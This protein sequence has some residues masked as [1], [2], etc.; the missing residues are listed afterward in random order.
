MIENINSQ[1]VFTLVCK[2]DLEMSAITLKQLTNFLITG[3]QLIVVD[4]GSLNLNDIH[5]LR[6][7]I[8]E[9]KF[10]LKEE[11]EDLIFNLIG[12]RKNILKYR[13][14]FVLAFKLIDIPLIAMSLTERFTYSDTD[15]LYLRNCRQ[16]FNS[17][18]NRY[19]RTDEIR[20]SV[21]LSKVFFKYKWKVPYRF[22]TGYFSFGL[23]D[24][25]LDF[26]NYYLGL[27]D[28]WNFKWLTEQTCWA[29]LFGRTSE[30]NCPALNEF[31]CRQ[32]FDDLKN[33]TLAI[34]LIGD[35]KKNYYKWMYK[36]SEYQQEVNTLPKFEKG[37]YIN[38]I[39]WGEK[40]LHRFI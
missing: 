31:V 25:D 36:D 20:L 18:S 37:K 29:L 38:F 24:Y 2:R 21:K 40:T 7:F 34:H 1:P 17:V 10:V 27:D 14:D 23:D 4:D 6:N 39:D 35:L 28:I 13:N 12:D 30:F 16:Y 11:R 19:L 22:N 5:F 9:A 15:I 33:D 3:Q 32:N 8:P 26:V